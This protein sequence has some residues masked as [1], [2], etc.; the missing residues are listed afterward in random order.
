LR[1][2]FPGPLNF[3]EATL[4]GVDLSGCSIEQGDFTSANLTGFRCSYGELTQCEFAGAVMAGADLGD[5]DGGPGFSGSKLREADLGGS[6]CRHTS[7]WGADLT[8]ANFYGSR[9]HQCDFS[10]RSS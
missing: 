10:R 7:F 8:K 9:L 2:M 1:T 6:R 4:A 5:T 3:R